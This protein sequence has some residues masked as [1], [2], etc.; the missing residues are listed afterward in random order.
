M[1]RLRTLIT[2]SLTIVLLVFALT[3]FFSPGRLQ[4]SSTTGNVVAGAVSNATTL[5]PFVRAFVDL[6]TVVIAFY[7]PTTAAQS[8]ASTWK[9]RRDQKD[10]ASPLDTTA[11]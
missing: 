6:Y 9:G 2:V 1:T 10:Q 7:F 4:V 3:W 11:R 8:I 5:H